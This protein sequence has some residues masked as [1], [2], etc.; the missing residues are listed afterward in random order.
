MTRLTHYKNN[1]KLTEVVIYFLTFNLIRPNMDCTSDKQ[2]RIQDCF[3]WGAV[4][5]RV[6]RLRGHGGVWGR[7]CPPPSKA[8]KMHFLNSNCTSWSVPFGNILLKIRYSFMIKYWLLSYVFLPP[9][10]FLCLCLNYSKSLVIKEKKKG[11]L[12]EFRLRNWKKNAI[13]KLNLRNLV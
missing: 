4:K 11:C 12:G 8:E 9:F 2:E 6:L 3:P 13:F 7:M 5:R 1:T 10:L